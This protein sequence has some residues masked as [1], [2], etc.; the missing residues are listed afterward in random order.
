MIAALVIQ[1]FPLYS[2]PS[3]PPKV[4]LPPP[5]FSLKLNTDAQ[6]H[7]RQTEV[8]DDVSFLMNFSWRTQTGYFLPGGIQ[9]FNAELVDVLL[10]KF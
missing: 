8:L 2:P 9:R 1:A 7:E 3:P 4:N 10:G 5:L 6:Q